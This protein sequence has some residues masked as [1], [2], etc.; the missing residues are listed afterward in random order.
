[1]L[2]LFTSYEMLKNTYTIIKESV[3]VER[4]ILIAQGITSG[5]RERLK[6]NFQSYEQAILFGTSSFWEGVDIPGEDLSS[7]VIVRL[8]FQPP[9]HPVYEAKA[10][11]LKES[12]EN[13][14]MEFALPNAVIKFKQGFGRLIRS[15][16]DRGIVFICDARIMTARYG[17]YFIRSIPDVPIHFDTTKNLMDKARSWF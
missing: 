15:S 12:G 5:S 6:K 16:Q 14:F 4:F 10:Q 1:M 8:P 11:Y 7:L 2:V 3:E 17:K 13:P 9:D